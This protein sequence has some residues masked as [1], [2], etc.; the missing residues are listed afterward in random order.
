MVAIFTVDAVRQYL[1]TALL[2]GLVYHNAGHPSLRL[3]TCGG[4]FGPASETT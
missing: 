4:S 3:I 2:S 1:K